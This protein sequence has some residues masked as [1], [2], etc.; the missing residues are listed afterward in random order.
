MRTILAAFFLLALA[1]CG[2]RADENFRNNIR[3]SGLD[4]CQNNL[5]EQLTRAGRWSDDMTSGI[6]DVCAC[7][8]DTNMEN[9]ST[10][11][12]VARAAR[13]RTPAER[14]EYDRIFADCREPFD[15]RDMSVAEKNANP[16][17]ASQRDLESVL[18]APAPGPA[19]P[20]PAVRAR[21]VAAL[22]SYASD[23]DY[24]AA[25]LRDRAEGRV[26]FA[27]DIGPDGRV[28]NCTIVTSSGSAALD[29]A[30]CRIMRSRARYEPARDARGAPAPDR[31]RGE[32]NWTLPKD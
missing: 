25:A 13:E 26:A 32:L 17:R 6:R 8:I 21:P 10:T 15:R 18:A 29:S 4:A 12:L 19:G 20:P 1:A 16:S 31:D 9:V 24:P 30:S 11:E 28:T 14:A 27:L 22:A 3:T 23:D 5:R 2:S 7:V